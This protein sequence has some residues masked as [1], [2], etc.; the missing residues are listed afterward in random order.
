MIQPAPTPTSQEAIDALIAAEGDKFRAAETLGLGSDG[1]AAA[2]LTAIIASD[3]QA[4]LS[5]TERLRTL[6]ILATFDTLQKVK[7]SLEASLGEIEPADLVKLFSALTTSL[8]RLSDAKVSTQNINV[9]EIAMRMLPAD[10]REAIIAANASL[11]DAPPNVMR[12][13]SASSEDVA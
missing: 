1:V 9:T 2:K 13:P 6:T 11:D 3:P 5:L 4:N 12:L 10:V 8:E 7:I